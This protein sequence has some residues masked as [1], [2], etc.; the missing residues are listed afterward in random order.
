MTSAWSSSVAL[1]ICAA[2]LLWKPVLMSPGS[3][4]PCPIPENGLEL[5]ISILED[6]PFTEFESGKVKGILGEIFA[7]IQKKCFLEPPGCKSESRN[8]TIRMRQFNS[9]TSFLSAIER[10]TTD[11]AFPITS[12]LKMDLSG[13]KYFGPGLKFDVFIESSGYSLIMDVENFNRRSNKIVF[14]ALLVNTWPI[15]VFTLLIAG[16]SGIFVWMLVST[17][18]R[19]SSQLCTHLKPEK[20][21]RPEGRVRIYEVMASIMISWP[22]FK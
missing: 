18:L 10:N 4:P 13:D 17:Y 1:V 5:R 14:D 3:P 19:R 15:F 20:K 16:I 12:S 22:G 6:P 8:V 7:E 9:T 11:I 2:V 21:F